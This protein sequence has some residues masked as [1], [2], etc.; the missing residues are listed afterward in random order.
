M[1]CLFLQTVYFRTLQYYLIKQ[2]ALLSKIFM[3][4]LN[5]VYSLNMT[6]SIVIKRR[7]HL[8]W[9]FNSY[10]SK[11]TFF[12]LTTNKKETNISSKS[13]CFFFLIRGQKCLK[14]R[15]II[16]F[17]KYFLYLSVYLY[18]NI[19]DSQRTEAH[20]NFVLVEICM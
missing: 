7:L 1:L 5:I 9:W 12:S 15:K 3:F 10:S 13:F 19:H 2:I 4:L 11:Q 20:R 14:R 6:D 18:S 16:N 8:I 17:Q